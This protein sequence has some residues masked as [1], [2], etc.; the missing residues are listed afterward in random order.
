MN[1][2]PKDKWKE[3][4]QIGVIPVGTFRI[5]YLSKSRKKNKFGAKKQTFNGAKYDSTLEAKV[6]EDLEWQVKS[7]D[8]VEVKRQVK[9]PLYVNGIV[10]TSYYI[11]FVTIDKHG[12]KK[13]IEVKGFETEVWKI[14]WKLCQ[15]L[16]DQIDPG[17]EWVI[18]KK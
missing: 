1:P 16:R 18:I 12:S 14:K 5:N 9:I 17:A 10:I 11:D 7:G 2:R 8:L 6:A 13:Y 3:P 15:A 4:E